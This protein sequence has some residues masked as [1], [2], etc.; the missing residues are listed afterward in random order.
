M[1]EGEIKHVPEIHPPL[2]VW[3]GGGRPGPSE[4]STSIFTIDRNDHKTYM[5]CTVACTTSYL[6]PAQD[7][8]MTKDQSSR[9][10]SPASGNTLGLGCS[11]AES[12]LSLTLMETSKHSIARHQMAQKN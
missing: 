6:L 10:A 1:G 3:R 2:Q 11:Y 9:D 4:L 12:G 8:A 7:P 5:N